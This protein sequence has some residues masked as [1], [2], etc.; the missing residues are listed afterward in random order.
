MDVLRNVP[1]A[2]VYIDNIGIF[3]SDWEH[4]I[5]QRLQDNGFT[6]NP[7]KCEWA[8]KEM[9][10]LGYR[11][12]PIGLKPWRN[13]IDAIL[14]LTVP[15]NA[16]EVVPLSVPLPFTTTCGRIDRISWRL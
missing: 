11:L 10:R 1:D 15:C 4:A 6:V 2:E 5:L 7:L 9:D 14:R 13:K 3:S 8:V 12:T 16:K